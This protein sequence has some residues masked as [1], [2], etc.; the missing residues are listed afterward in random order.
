MLNKKVYFDAN[1]VLNIIDSNRKEHLTAKR[2]WKNLILEKCI[3]IISEDILTNVFY[4]SKNKTEALNFFKF[5]QYKWQ[6]VPFG[7]DVIKN[8]IDLALEKKLDLEDT[9]QCLCAK[10]NGCE[11]LIT[12]DKKF[13]NCGI[14]ICT[15]EEF[16]KEKIDVQK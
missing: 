14:S 15:I 7:K 8:S 5:I 4:I 12:N 16:L 11:I 2:M 3:I 10:E 13:Y 9:L 1:I 6:I